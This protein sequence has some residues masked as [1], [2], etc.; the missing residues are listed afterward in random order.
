[1]I[2]LYSE[3]NGRI[4][5]CDFEKRLLSRTFKYY[6]I[7]IMKFLFWDIE[8]K[9]TYITVKHWSYVVLFGAEASLKTLE[10]RILRERFG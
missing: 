1:M 10:H 4:I 3:L 2:E 9:R 6:D 8:R 5:C 7:V